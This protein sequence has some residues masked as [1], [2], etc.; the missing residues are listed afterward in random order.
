MWIYLIFYV[1]M[2]EPMEI[3]ETNK[4]EII[5]KKEFKVKKII[6]KKTEF[7]IIFYKIK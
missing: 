3:Q 6:N 4:N 1:L 5:I 7:K 2:L